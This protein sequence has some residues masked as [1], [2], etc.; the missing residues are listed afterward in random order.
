MNIV[1]CYLYRLFFII[2]TII[3][4]FLNVFC[5]SFFLKT[6]TYFFDSFF[7][8]F[9]GNTIPANFCVFTMVSFS[10]ELQKSTRATSL[11]AAG[12]RFPEVSGPASMLLLQCRWVLLTGACSAGY[13]SILPSK[14]PLMRAPVEPW[15]LGMGSQGSRWTMAIDWYVFSAWHVMWVCQN[16]GAIL[17]IP[18]L[19]LILILFRHKL[20]FWG[21]PV[22]PPFWEKT[23]M[24][25]HKTPPSPRSIQLCH[26]AGPWLCLALL[27]VISWCS[28]ARRWHPGHPHSYPLNV[29][30][31]D[32]QFW[33]CWF[34][35]K[36]P[37]LYFLK[38]FEDVLEIPTFQHE[39]FILGCAW[40]GVASGSNH[41]T[42]PY[43]I[44]IDMWDLP[45][46]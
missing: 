11:Q 16:M 24:W 15:A 25:F 18:A 46:L 28:T 34:F 20:C 14:M 43:I 9:L 26:M 35:L 45:Q 17:K 29:Q 30:D 41:H 3:I 19:M 40:N 38:M 37:N 6:C 31:Q 12:S 22:F 4:I 36:F 2:M 27:H 13:R 33:R 23:L 8:Y 1:A 32:L 42:S 21:I 7:T 10:L 44:N 39:I 5:N